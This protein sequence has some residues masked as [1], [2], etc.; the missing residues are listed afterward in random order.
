M[1]DD[2]EMSMSPRNLIEVAQCHTKN[3]DLEYAVVG[4]CRA[5]PTTQSSGNGIEIG[6]GR[7]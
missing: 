4:E 5:V 2:S 7:L 1:R 6:L 3:I